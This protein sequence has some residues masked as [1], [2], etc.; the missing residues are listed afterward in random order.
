MPEEKEEGLILDKK[1]TDILVANII[2]TSKYFEI[3]FDNLQ[4]QIDLKFG[5]LQQQMDLRF[6][7]V[8]QQIDH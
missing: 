5:Y 6:D 3:R 1:T 7:H 4:Q 8:Q 2:P